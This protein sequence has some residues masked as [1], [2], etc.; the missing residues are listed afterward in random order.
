[1]R[2]PLAPWLDL[3]RCPADGSELREQGASLRCVVCSACYPY[4]DGIVRFVQADGAPPL[5]HELKMREMASRDAEAEAYDAMFDPRAT[6][7]EVPPCLDALAPAPADVVCELG[8][9]TGRFTVRFADRVSR[10]VALDFSL[11]SLLVLRDRLTEP[12]RARTLLIQ[13]DACRPPLSRGAFH[14]VAAFDMLQHLPDADQRQQVVASAAQLLRP[15]GTFTATAYHWSKHKKKMAARGEGDYASKHGHHGSGIFYYNFEEPELS[16]AWESA[17]L[18]VDRVR[19]LQIGFRGA[20]LL[21]PLRVPMN[22]LLS[23]TAWGIARSHQLLVRGYKRGVRG[24]ESGV[25]S[26][27]STVRSRA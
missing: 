2:L 21:G 3:L 4:A 24:Q 22:R 27:G 8:A 7:I 15:G 19:G 9:G 18:H 17:S 14:K 20:R 12:M 1:M 23:G 11:R 5:D 13:A 25:R 10:L 16:R 26:Q 6:A